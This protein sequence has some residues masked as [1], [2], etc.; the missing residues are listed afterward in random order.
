MS[1]LLVGYRRCSTDSQD[2]TAQIDTLTRLG[3]EAQRTY[4]DH[5]L[6]GTNRDRPGL[7]EAL[8]AVREGDML[9]VSKLDRLAHSVPDARAIADELTGRKVKLNIGGSVYDPS[10][11]AQ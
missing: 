2:L 4:V 3:V 7:R 9:V 11:S 8:A 5:G 1:E 6:A 10:G